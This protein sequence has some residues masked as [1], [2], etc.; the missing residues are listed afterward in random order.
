MSQLFLIA[1]DVSDDRRLRQVANTLL[2]YGQRVQYSV[3]ECHIENSQ[4]QGLKTE[5]AQHINPEEDRIHICPLC[6]KDEQS[7][8][9]DG[10]RYV[11]QDR[12]YYML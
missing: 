8:L 10:D 5:L 6:G 4:L 7:I 3:F 2:N 11:S 12:D 1:F 9:V